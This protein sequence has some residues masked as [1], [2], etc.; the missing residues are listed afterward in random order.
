[1][2]TN[3]SFPTQLN[4]YNAP[5]L[6]NFETTVIDS[7]QQHK[8][9]LIFEITCWSSYQKSHPET[10]PPLTWIISSDV[11]ALQTSSGIFR[12]NVSYDSVSAN[13]DI[14]CQAKCIYFLG[15]PHDYATLLFQTTS[16]VIFCCFLSMG[17]LLVSESMLGG[18]FHFATANVNP[19]FHFC[20]K[21]QYHQSNLHTYFL[22]ILSLFEYM[23]TCTLIVSCPFQENSAFW[24]EHQ[25]FFHVCY[26]F[27]Y[28]IAMD[29]WCRWY[30]FHL[31]PW[32]AH[33]YICLQMG[34]FV[35]R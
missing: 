26:D 31:R 34:I 22:K 25:I 1:M 9:N 3:D 15:T 14:L 7:M 24:W 33:W 27:L 30:V 4:P 13:I 5:T 19:W 35:W 11:M 32:C 29:G 8:N 20:W 2:V 12:L 17:K 23:A 21:F 28:W 10:T 18:F 16:I 6:E